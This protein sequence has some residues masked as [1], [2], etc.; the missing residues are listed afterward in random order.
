MSLIVVEHPL[1]RH[2]LSILRD[3]QTSCSMFREILSQVALLMLPTV[4]SDLATNKVI[5]ETPIGTASERQ[6]VEEVVVVPILRAGLGMMQPFVELVPNLRVCYLDINRNPQTLMP[7]VRRSWLPETLDGACAAI[8]DPMLATGRITSRATQLVK[9]KGADRVKVMCLIAAP[10]GVD[11]LMQQHPD[12]QLYAA[13]V[14]DHLNAVGYIV[15]GLGDAGDRM[16][17]FDLTFPAYVGRKSD[18][19]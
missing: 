3:R 8:V 1:I 13:A 10:E 17:G 2:R 5:V 6:I 14:D 9:E 19:Q 7:D 15:P 12:V 16:T 18:G 11:C 4:L